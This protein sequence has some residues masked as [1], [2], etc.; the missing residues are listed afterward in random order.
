MTFEL[1]NLETMLK[2]QKL[3]KLVTPSQVP[4]TLKYSVNTGNINGSK[5]DGTVGDGVGDSVSFSSQKA[6]VDLDVNSSS[7]KGETKEER[8]SIAEGKVSKSTTSATNADNNVSS[9]ESAESQAKS[10]YLEA[11]D[12]ANAAEDT[13]NQAE[14]KTT[15]A[16]EKSQAADKKEQAAQTKE[17]EA[18]TAEETA[19]KQVTAVFLLKLSYNLF[20]I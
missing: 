20:N 1:P 6:E 17:Q 2:S 14:V 18:Q 7:Q 12:K 4:A 19:A 9:A 3:S 11:D 16:K 15:Q 5:A 8:I 13:F 10:A